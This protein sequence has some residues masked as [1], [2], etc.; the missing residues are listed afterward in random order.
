MLEATRAH[1]VSLNAE[2]L[3]FKQS[4]LDFFGHTLTDQGIQQAEDKLEAIRNMKPPSN[5]KELQ[6][7][8]GMVTYLNR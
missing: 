1:N 3:Q 7:I 6:T 2:K 4:K 5:V 8:L